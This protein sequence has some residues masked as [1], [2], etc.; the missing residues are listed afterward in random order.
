MP[1]V[2][3]N[4]DGSESTELELNF[5]GVEK[6]DFSP[7]PNGRYLMKVVDFSV[8]KTKE[9]NDPIIKLQLAPDVEPGD[10]IATKRVYEQIACVPPRDGKKG[11]LWKAREVLE[12][13]T[14]ADI[15]QNNIRISKSDVMGRRVYCTLEESSYSKPKDPTD[16]DSE[17]VTYR[18]NKVT[19]WESDFDSLAVENIIIS[20]NM[21]N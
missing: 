16:P 13:I 8:G 17:K 7:I 4:P 18:N 1:D 21:S 15:D 11:S 14:G 5:Q 6:Q 10:P 20:G 9:K 19:K 2:N 12:A 3:L